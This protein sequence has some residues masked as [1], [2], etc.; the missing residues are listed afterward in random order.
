MAPTPP[1]SITHS[2]V[3]ARPPEFRPAT[4]PRLPHRRPSRAGPPPQSRT[5]IPLP[6]TN[7]VHAAQISVN[8]E[9]A[10]GRERSQCSRADTKAH[11][12]KPARFRADPGQRLE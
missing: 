11:T 6:P 1:A 4:A 9:G 8:G 3:N 2:V 5:H 12:V 7:D 10:V